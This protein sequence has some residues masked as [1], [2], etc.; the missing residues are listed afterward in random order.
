MRRGDILAERVEFQ[1]HAASGGM[2]QVFRARDV[3]SGEHVA[4]KMLRG[5]VEAHST[6]FVHETRALS[7]LSHPGIV[8]YVAHGVA[9][10]GEPYLAMEWLD[11]ED[12][13][14]RLARGPLG[15][16]DSIAVARSV[17]EALG[18]AHERR[19]VHRDLKP[20]NIFLVDGRIDRVK[21]LDFGIARMGSATRMTHRGGIVGTPGYMAPEQVQGHPEVDARTDVFALGCVLFE[22][23]AGQA[24]FVAEHPMAL[25]AKVVFAEP[26]RLCE[27]RPEAPEA[28]DQLVS[29]MLTKDLDGR[30]RNG[31]A[32]A[33]ALAALEARMS[34]RGGQA[35]LVALTRVERR[36]VS[37]V[38]IG[39][40]AEG[41]SGAARAAG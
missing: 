37:I 12:L 8:R 16:Q 20:S 33:E 19:I 18:L 3:Q 23:V 26:P 35:P 9:A 29:R 27:V 39:R 10:S 28:L 38:L 36:A 17:A 21:L 5:D 30:P 1:Q 4:V 25:L 14:G 6:R 11:G 32:V 41:P 2:G 40:A 24:A 13:S 22:C 7:E 34:S 15:V 31:A